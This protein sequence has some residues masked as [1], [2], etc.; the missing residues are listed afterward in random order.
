MIINVK[1]IYIENIDNKYDLSN[2]DS[3][4]KD[5]SEKEQSMWGFSLQLLKHDIE[6][7]TYDTEKDREWLE[8]FLKL[9]MKMDVYY[10]TL[11]EWI[12]YMSCYMK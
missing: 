2:I 8:M 3:F 1:N 7:E 10:F 12:D 4:E 5:Y 6:K 11:K 9:Y